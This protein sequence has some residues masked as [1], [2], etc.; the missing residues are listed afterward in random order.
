LCLDELDE[1]F[2]SVV[3]WSDAPPRVLEVNPSHKLRFCGGQFYIV[4]NQQHNGQPLW[5]RPANSSRKGA[6]GTD[7]WLYCSTVGT[8]NIGGRRA[9][10]HR[11]QCHSAYIFSRERHKGRAPHRM[12]GTWWR[13]HDGNFVSDPTITVKCP[14]RC[15]VVP[16]TAVTEEVIN[17]F[18]S[19]DSDSDQEP[20]DYPKETAWRPTPPGPGASWVNATAY[21]NLS[22]RSAISRESSETFVYSEAGA[23]RAA[24]R[25]ASEA[26]ATRADMD[27]EPTDAL[28]QPS[29]RPLQ[30]PFSRAQ[31]RNNETR[32]HRSQSQPVA[33]TTETDLGE[34]LHRRLLQVSS[35]NQIKKTNRRSSAPPKPSAEE[36]RRRADRAHSAHKRGPV[37]L[38]VEFVQ[39]LLQTRSDVL[40]CVFT[41]R[42]VGIVF[43]EC[44]LP[45]TVQ[46][47]SRGSAAYVQGVRRG[48]EVVKINGTDAT[49]SSM[50]YS[51]VQKFFEERYAMLP[52]EMQSHQSPRGVPQHIKQSMAGAR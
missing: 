29:P 31:Q 15:R 47:V 32:Q 5:I 28:P 41:T 19:L 35:P 13:L 20:M 49:R 37:T 52:S 50:R 18:E 12:N 34:E 25:A 30:F 7:M 1:E 11:F 40:R 14:G 51:D 33:E 4:E 17:D 43:D 2:D 39:P 48:M 21:Q 3:A 6:A 23:S 22:P 42:P 24:S 10:E 38:E 45:L 44:E 46:T 9:L 16:S 26:D 8:W 27:D 36:L